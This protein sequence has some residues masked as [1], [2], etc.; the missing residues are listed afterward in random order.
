MKVE[1]YII[2]VCHK[3]LKKFFL[4]ICKLVDHIQAS[5]VPEGSKL[6]RWEVKILQA[7]LGSRQ[8]F[9]YEAYLTKAIYLSLF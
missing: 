2:F 9:L 6:L 7:P 4:N 8:G 5:R 3:Y 1:L